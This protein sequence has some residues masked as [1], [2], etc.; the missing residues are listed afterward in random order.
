MMNNSE[1]IMW[2][3]VISTFFWQFYKAIQYDSEKCNERI[4][5]LKGQKYEELQ[6]RIQIQKS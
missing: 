1:I 2:G 6:S 3:I 5:K 4:N